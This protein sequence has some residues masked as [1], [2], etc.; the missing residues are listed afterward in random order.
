[1]LDARWLAGCAS[2]PARAD[3]VLNNAFSVDVMHEIQGEFRMPGLMLP[4]SADLA[5][6]D[7]TRD[8][9]VANMIQLG[10]IVVVQIWI[11][12]STLSSLLT[13]SRLGA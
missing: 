6:N 11:H 12:I 5:V 2:C 7:L 8:Q 10:F 13:D 3:Y 4:L 1:M 9:R